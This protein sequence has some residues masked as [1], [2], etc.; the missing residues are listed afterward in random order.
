M[1]QYIQPTVTIVACQNEDLCA[2]TTS[3]V[4]DGDNDTWEE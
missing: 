2:T 4:V 3:V 1:K